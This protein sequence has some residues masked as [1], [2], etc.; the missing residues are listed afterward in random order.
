MK[1]RLVMQGF[2]M[3]REA[4]PIAAALAGPVAA[5]QPNKGTG[6]AG[7]PRCAGAPRLG[8]MNIINGK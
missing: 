8:V 3:P 4:S 5:A 2:P 7:A 1:L 6:E